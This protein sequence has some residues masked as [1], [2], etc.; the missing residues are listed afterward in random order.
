[1][2][3]FKEL[4]KVSKT[5]QGLFQHY[6]INLCKKVHDT[7]WYKQLYNAQIEDKKDLTLIM[8]A[9]LKHT[10]YFIKALFEYV[11]SN[12]VLNQ[13]SFVK[14]VACGESK[15]YC[16]CESESLEAI[17]ATTRGGEC[18]KKAMKKDL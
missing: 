18:Q 10:Q 16:T 12:D 11:G 13:L 9:M 8:K 17:T 15:D 14:S 5:L 7:K 3:L 6:E 2:R 1:M 4:N